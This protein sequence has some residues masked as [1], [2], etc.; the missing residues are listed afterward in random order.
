MKF[1]LVIGLLCCL[2][3]N[4]VL[5][6]ANIDG[7]KPLEAEQNFW[8]LKRLQKLKA[9]NNK[10]KDT[11]KVRD[12]TEFA[13][14]I[15][16]E[17]FEG[18][19]D[20][21]D[22]DEDEYDYDEDDYDYLEGSGDYLDDDL[23]LSS[24]KEVKIPLESDDND[25]KDDF[26]FVE[27]KVHHKKVSKDDF[28]YEYYNDLLYGNED[29]EEYLQ[30]LEQDLGKD[31]INIDNAAILEKEEVIVTETAGNSN[32]SWFRP[33]YVFLMLSSALVSFA[34][35]ILMFILCRKSMLNRQ[36]KQKSVPFVV[37]SGISNSRYNSK[38]STPIVKPSYYQRVPTS[39]NEM[40]QNVELGMPT[41]NTQKPLL[42]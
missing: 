7:T 38:Q 8:K 6:E 33:A 11:L 32:G 13:K 23:L 41:D 39:T 42:T 17:D 3:V 30:E 21:D 9:V 28:L 25:E 24:D 26:H 37:T 40:K 27:D 20:D 10:L 1:Y 36:Q 14:L 4:L 5:S 12:E 31:L 15:A 29:N 35:F 34:L 22:Y 19:G 18:S 2:Y 16:D